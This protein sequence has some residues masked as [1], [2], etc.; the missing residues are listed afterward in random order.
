VKGSIAGDEATVAYLITLLRTGERH[1]RTLEAVAARLRGPGSRA[2]AGGG[3]THSGGAGNPHLRRQRQA[4]AGHDAS[5]PQQRQLLRIAE[6][7][8]HSATVA[9]PV[10]EWHPGLENHTTGSGGGELLGPEGQRRLVLLLEALGVDPGARDPSQRAAALAA[11]LKAFR[12]GELGRY[13]LDD[14]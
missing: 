10:Q 5:P 1:R 2:S 9:L 4:G 7:L 14:V 11:V 3:G 12:V 6:G 8:L 13:T